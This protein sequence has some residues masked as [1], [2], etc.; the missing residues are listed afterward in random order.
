VRCAASAE[1]E[2]VIRDAG[3][4]RAVQQVLRLAATPVVPDDDEEP[5]LVTIV[6]TVVSPPTVP[7]IPVVVVLSLVVVVIPVVT[8]L[9]GDDAAIV[10]SAQR[11]PGVRLVGAQP[12]DVAI[13]GQHSR[14]AVPHEPVDA[15]AEWLR[16]ARWVG[17][18]R[19]AHLGRNRRVGPVLLSVST[20]TQDGAGTA[21]GRDAEQPSLELEF[22]AGQHGG[23]HDPAH[24]PWPCRWPSQHQEVVAPRKA[25]VVAGEA[26]TTGRTASRDRRP[27]GPARASVGPTV[28][29]ARARAATATAPRTGGR[30]DACFLRRC[31]S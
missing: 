26:L 12:H 10:V 13:E 20:G 1:T 3:A 9:E 16:R 28:C 22:T 4:E 7:V 25:M 6:M 23:R 2:L 19:V 8:S 30:R 5:G 27:S 21:G 17:R 11:L 14:G 29:R 18:S 31:V 15:V 24:H